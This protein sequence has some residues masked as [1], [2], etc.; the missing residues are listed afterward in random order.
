MVAKKKK[1]MEETEKDI[2]R[3]I[4]RE[5]YQDMYIEDDQNKRFRIDIE[6]LKDVFYCIPFI[7]G[8]KFQLYFDRGNI[9]KSFIQSLANIFIQQI[10]N[11]INFPYKLGGGEGK[12]YRTIHLPFFDSVPITDQYKVWMKFI[13]ESQISLTQQITQE[14]LRV[15]KW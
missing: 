12:S 14:Y 6:G 5:L 13:I 2:I 11:N 10:P 15:S 1:T 9:D 4:L 7:G 3:E 8:F